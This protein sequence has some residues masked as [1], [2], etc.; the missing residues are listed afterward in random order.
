MSPSQTQHSRCASAGKGEPSHGIRVLREQSG[1]RKSGMVLTKAWGYWSFG[2]ALA[3]TRKRA[4]TVCSEGEGPG[5]L[6]LPRSAAFSAPW[7]RSWLFPPP[8]SDCC[9]G[10]LLQLFPG[11]WICLFSKENKCKTHTGAL[12]RAFL[13]GGLIWIV[14]LLSLF[15]NLSTS[16]DCVEHESSW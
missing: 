14:E 16:E 8:I 1:A 7:W 11:T 5:G 6:T 13:C 10:N 12:G 3:C 2:A 4:G 15:E 9:L